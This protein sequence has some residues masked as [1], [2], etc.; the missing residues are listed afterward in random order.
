MVG[1]QGTFINRDTGHRAQPG[2]YVAYSDYIILNCEL[3]GMKQD[4]EMRLEQLQTHIKR[5]S[6]VNRENDFLKAQI[7]ELKQRWP[8][9]HVDALI[10]AEADNAKLKAEVEPILEDMRKW[11]RLAC[12]YQ[13]NL[14][15]KEA[16]NA[17]FKA[18]NQDLENKLERLEEVD[19]TADRLYD[20][21]MFGI[22][23]MK[24]KDDEIARLKAENER[25][26]KAGDELRYAGH[27]LVENFYDGASAWNEAL[28]AWNAAKE[29]KPSA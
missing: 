6:V 23:M 8:N 7:E 16:E 9:Y 27:R 4:N 2:E 18:E 12:Y 1:M 29:G 26:R 14:N 15:D 21:V 22:D 19:K 17:R 20:E 11:H 5:I 24:S 28:H 3:N 25:L 13:D 10:K